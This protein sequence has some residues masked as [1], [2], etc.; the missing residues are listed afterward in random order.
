MICIIPEGSIAKRERTE[1]TFHPHILNPHS[2]VPRYGPLDV[3][4]W[5]KWGQISLSRVQKSSY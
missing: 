3:L 2:S 5:S 4:Y 1:L